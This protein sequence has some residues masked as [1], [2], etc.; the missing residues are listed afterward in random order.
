MSQFIRNLQQ[1]YKNSDVLMKFI[2][3]NVA[4]FIV[5]KIISVLFTLF[6]VD[7][8][9]L[10]AFLA[11]PSD[12][13]A[14]ATRFWTPFSYM[15][16]HEGLWHILFNM[17]WLYW[18]GQI[19]LQYFTG[20]NLGSLY[21]LGGLAGAFFYLAAFNIF[22]YYIDMGHGLM[23]GAS[24]AVMAIVFA[25]AF[26][27]PDVSLNLLFI[28][29]IKIVYIAIFV[30]ILDFL[31]LD[32]LSNPGGHIAHIGGAIVGYF[33]AMHYKKGKDITRWMSRLIDWFVNLFKPT[34]KMKVTYHHTET[35][36]E[37]NFRKH[38]E[39]QEIDAILDKIKHSGYNNLSKEEKR[40]LF[41]AGKK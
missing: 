41:D 27:R 8:G 5:L 14:L 15:F 20:R 26:Y 12:L 39:S 7:A 18:F 4:I 33:F 32:S 19:F 9:Q 17:L 30:F 35:D 21:V 28:G 1:R 29:K 6:K 24:A 25:T 23:I 10:I 22:P 40:K 13:Y 11:I 38:R 37:Y 36:Q 3:V 16:V 2:F 31:S 34:S